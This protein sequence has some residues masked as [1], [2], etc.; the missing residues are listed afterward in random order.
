[1]IQKTPQERRELRLEFLQFLYY[2]KRVTKPVPCTGYRWSKM[3]LKAVYN[4]EL[5]EKYRCKNL[6]YWRFTALKKSYAKDGIY[7]MSHLY[8]AGLN[9]DQDELDRTER[10]YKKFKENNGS[11]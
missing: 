7:C 10:Q 1:M 8:A 3:P 6:A 4:L 5:R 11:N 9:H 2:V